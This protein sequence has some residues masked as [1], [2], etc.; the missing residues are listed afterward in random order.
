MTISLDIA[1]LERLYAQGDT[2][3]EHIVREVYARIRQKGERPDWITLV[4]E[5][6][7]IANAFSAPRGPLYGIPFAVKD[8]IDVAGLPTTCACPEF[9]YVAR[10][11]GD[12]GRASGAG[13]R[14]PDRQDQ[15]RS[16]RHR[17]QWNALALWHPGER[18]QSRLYFRRFELRLGCRRRRGPRVFLTRHRHCRLRPRARLPSTTS[19]A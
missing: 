10:P 4:D 13:R 1:S 3:P 9:A 8:N 17:S 7:A 11:F 6:A 16:V 15:S 14:D 12:S 2:T 18:L 5:D 19:S